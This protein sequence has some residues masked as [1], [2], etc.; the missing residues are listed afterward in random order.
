[1]P[2][3]CSEPGCD[4]PAY[5]RGLCRTHYSRLYRKK[6]ATGK[7]EKRRGAKGECK[8]RVVFWLPPGIAAYA[9]S[10]KEEVARFLQQRE[11][12]SRIL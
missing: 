1:M 10:H 6:I 8:V 11:I 9:E 2:E 4:K 5:T 7:I 12:E 3:T